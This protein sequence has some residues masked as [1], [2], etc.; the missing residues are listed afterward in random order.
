MYSKL[1]KMMCISEKDI[2]LQWKS[3]KKKKLENMPGGIYPFFQGTMYHPCELSEAEVTKV[4]V[5]TVP[6]ELPPALS[7]VLLNGIR[8]LMLAR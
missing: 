6:V 1:S 3:A 8:F 4:K 5:S 7:F 2:Y